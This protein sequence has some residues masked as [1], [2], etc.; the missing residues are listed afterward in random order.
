MPPEQKDRHYLG[1]RQ[2]LK[3][4]L[5]DNPGSL[6]DY[7]VLELLLGYALPRRDTKPLAKAVLK[8]FGS[9]RGALAASRND[10][11]KI[12]GIGKGISTFWTLWQEFWARS[13]QSG[14]PE[15]VMLNTP[16]KVVR[17]ARSRINFLRNEEF[18]IILVDN[19][20]RLISFEKVSQGIVDQ[21]VV[22]PRAIISRALALDAGGIILAHNHPGGDPQPSSQDI[23]LTKKVQQIAAELNLRI[24]DH[25]I[26]AEDN[27]FSFQDQAII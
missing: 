5:I 21:A 2:R 4:K 7:E 3:K 16:E 12:P 1:H 13:E 27:Y 23:E 11:E 17:L 20:N 14:L 9:L 26:I 10:L 22:Y 25:V 8:E 19:K 18:W 15:K 6:E 24:L